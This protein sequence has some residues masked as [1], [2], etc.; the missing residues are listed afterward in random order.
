MHFG[1]L[2][3]C[4]NDIVVSSQ[5]AVVVHL[6]LFHYLPLARGDPLVLADVIGSADLASDVRSLSASSQHAMATQFRMDIGL[7]CCLV[8]LRL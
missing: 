6:G 3:S 5:I 2:P 7:Q 4:Q 1:S 8:S